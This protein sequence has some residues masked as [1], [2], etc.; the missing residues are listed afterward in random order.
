MVLSASS[1]SLFSLRF[2]IGMH[3]VISLDWECVWFIL[4]LFFSWGLFPYL[5]MYDIRFFTLDR[6]S[7]EFFLGRECMIFCVPLSVGIYFGKFY[8]GLEGVRCLYPTL[9]KNWIVNFTLAKKVLDSQRGT[10]FENILLNRV[11]LNERLY[12]RW[13]VKTS[14]AKMG[15]IGLDNVCSMTVSCQPFLSLLESLDNT[16]MQLLFYAV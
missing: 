7:G 12:W 6:D 15:K 2:P 4:L 5:R 8:L 1:Y 9:D 14:L 3:R 10:F 16:S 13:L 11:L